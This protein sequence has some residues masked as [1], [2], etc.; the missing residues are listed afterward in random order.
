MKRAILFVM[1]ALSIFSSCKKENLCDCIKGTGSIKKE[2]RAASDFTS[3]EVHKNISVI[4]TQDNINSVEVKAGENL[5]PLIKTEVK[6]GQLY[7]T[8]HN[9]CNW[10]RSYSKEIVVYVY[11]KNLREISSY[12]ARDITSSNT[13]TSSVITILN[14]LN[15]DISLDIN[16]DESY[17]KQMGAGGDITVTG[18]TNFNYIFSQGYGYLHLENLESTKAM[19]SQH[20]TSDIHMNASDELDVEITGIGSV[21]YSG[22]PVVSQR[23]SPGSGKLIHN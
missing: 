10:V 14:F 4:I 17:T 21:F 16:A 12:S 3:I 1:V 6:N 9:T 18:H 7:I 19:V 5:L 11:A 23:P 13:I 22:N 2:Q 20:G 15:G 8:N